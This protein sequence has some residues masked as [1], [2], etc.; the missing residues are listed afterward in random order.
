MEGVL[1]VGLL[2]VEHVL[3][4]VITGEVLLLLLL[5]LLVGEGYIKVTGE[6][7]LLKT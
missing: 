7:F 5:L 1:V 4:V 3:V 2:N 6:I